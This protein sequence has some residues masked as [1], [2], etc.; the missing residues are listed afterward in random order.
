M[1]APGQQTAALHVRS[2]EE[3]PL[4]RRHFSTTAAMIIRL[5]LKL[6]PLKPVHAAQVHVVP[7]VQKS[8]CMFAG[9]ARDACTAP[10]GT[11]YGIKAAAVTAA[12][13]QHRRSPCKQL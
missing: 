4:A 9:Q 13:R 6:C 10:P 2:A 3:A 7:D 12:K 5:S 1:R 11:L 8:P